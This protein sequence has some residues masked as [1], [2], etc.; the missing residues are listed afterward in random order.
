M[1]HMQKPDWEWKV[2][3]FSYGYWK[4]KFV[5]FLTRYRSTIASS[6]KNNSKNKKL[7]IYKILKIEKQKYSKLVFATFCYF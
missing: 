7:I 3:L 4:C 2:P 6:S 1:K 5:D